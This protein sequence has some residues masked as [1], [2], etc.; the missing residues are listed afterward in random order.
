MAHQLTTQ[1]LF[2]AWN[3]S[4]DQNRRAVVKEL[5]DIYSHS[6]QYLLE[7]RINARFLEQNAERLRL[8]AD[9]S[10]NLLRW[11]TDEIAA[12]Y[13]APLSR[14]VNGSSEGL[15]PYTSGGLLDE[16][17][18]Q[19]CKW[20]YFCREAAIRPLVNNG[21]LSFDLV[22]PDRFTV[23]R[24]PSD[25]LLFLAIIIKLT[26]NRFAVWTSE[27]HFIADEQFNPLHDEENPDHINPYG[28]IP[29][30][31]THNAYPA[32]TF[33]NERDS[34][35]L[36]SAT[37]EA[38]LKLTD[39]NHLRHLQSFKQLV[40][41]GSTDET[42]A[43]MAVDPS[44]AGLIKNPQARVEVLDM[45]AN[46]ETHLSTAFLAFKP[47]LTAHGIWKDVIKGSGEASS[48]YALRIKMHI[49]NAAWN[50]L[51]VLWT[52]YE[53]QLYNVASVVLQVD[54]GIAL[55]SGSLELEFSDIGP[56]GNPKERVD[57]CKALQN[58]GFS[59][60]AALRDVYGKS[61]EWIAKNEAELRSEEIASAPMSIPAA[62]AP[63]EQEEDLEDVEVELEEG[64]TV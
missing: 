49:Q 21:T 9:T 27:T 29:Y 59:R 26:D 47:V 15:E 6:W 28:V 14:T 45:Q 22:S 19:A 57:L 1:N 41:I 10:I 2:N 17:L 62:P 53:R 42:L 20:T 48:G 55:P 32:T 54:A 37:L 56:G 40:I 36:R 39:H 7:E 51:R 46:L 44:S 12:I 4:A 30:I 3:N 34:L 64:L 50:K 8:V 13:S 58:A 52:L 60:A 43:R 33:F 38:G 18:D 61:E 31:V 25:P 16:F 63:D 11:V 35:A 5:V 23:I 24:H